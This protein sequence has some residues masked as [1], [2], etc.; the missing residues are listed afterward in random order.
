MEAARL[1][2][3]LRR[4]GRVDTII[5]FGKAAREH[6]TASWTAIGIYT[7]FRESKALGAAGWPTLWCHYL[8]T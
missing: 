4:M 1:R 7:A 3:E 6:C 8:E 5:E 2:M